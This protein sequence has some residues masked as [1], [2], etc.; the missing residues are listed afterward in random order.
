MFEK[1]VDRRSAG[2]TPLEQARFVQLYL[3]DVFHEICTTH[4]LRYWLDYGTLIGA[5]RHNEFIPW[6]DDLDVSMPYEDY[7]KFLEIAP[8]L[9]P[10]PI[11]LQELR[12]TPGA[13]FR[14]TKLRDRS[15]FYCEADTIASLPCGIFIDIF[16]W[17]R[18]PRLPRKVVSL[19]AHFQYSCLRHAGQALSRPR[20]SAFR[21]ILDCCISLLWRLAYNT[22]YHLFSLVRRTMPSRTWRGPQ[23]SAEAYYVPEN[24]LFPLTLHRF[25]DREYLV[26]HDAAYVLE[27]EF[28]D[29]RTLPPENKRAVH[30]TIISATMTPPDVDWALR[31]TKN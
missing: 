11:L 23:D 19:W 25:E 5:M 4:H 13:A 27:Q 9:L 6:D 7:V 24:R 16:P 10:E 22:A 26:P 12:K 30:A 29:W 17:T 3:L 8:S 2:K 31:R 28:G 15:S 20:V 18:A 21:K 1:I 14:F